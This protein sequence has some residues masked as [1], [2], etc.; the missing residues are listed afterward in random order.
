MF[1]LQESVAECNVWCFTATKHVAAF[2]PRWIVQNHFYRFCSILE[3][4]KF[5]SVQELSTWQSGKWQYLTTGTPE[6]PSCSGVWSSAVGDGFL[7]WW[8]S[9]SHIP[10]ISRGGG[11]NIGREKGTSFG[12]PPRQHGSS[13]ARHLGIILCGDILLVC[14]G[15]KRSEIRHLLLHQNLRKK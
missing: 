15:T 12:R 8:S 13:P 4:S 1:P 7:L 3:S 14:S 10:C 6:D 9:F 11:D 5:S 2:Q